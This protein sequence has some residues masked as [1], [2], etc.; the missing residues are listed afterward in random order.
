LFVLFYSSF[1]YTC[2][3]VFLHIQ[4]PLRECC[5]IRSGAC[6]GKLSA[7]RTSTFAIYL[8]AANIGRLLHSPRT[9]HEESARRQ[10]WCMPSARQQAVPSCD[11]KTLWA[12]RQQMP[13]SPWLQICSPQYPPH[14]CLA[15]RPPCIADRIWQQNP[16]DRSPSLKNRA[17][18]HIRTPHNTSHPIHTARSYFNVSFLIAFPH[19]HI[20]I[21]PKSHAPLRICFALVLFWIF[22]CFCGFVLVFFWEYSFY[23][24][25]KVGI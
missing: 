21:T 4:S 22:F 14:P 12:V 25:L 18:H 6:M 8:R 1:V 9:S 15:V 10:V 11:S 2:V 19:P 20:P 17:P 7:R 24:K 23:W 16:L 13:S 3:Y 5:S